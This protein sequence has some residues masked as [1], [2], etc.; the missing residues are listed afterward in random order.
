[1]PDMPSNHLLAGMQ[2]CYCPKDVATHTVCYYHVHGCSTSSSWSNHIVFREAD[3][4]LASSTVT[5]GPLTS[6]PPPGPGESL[7]TA[8]VVTKTAR[9]ATYLVRRQF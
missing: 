6:I 1:M 3:L 9:A 8:F 2:M 7:V 5:F 4:P